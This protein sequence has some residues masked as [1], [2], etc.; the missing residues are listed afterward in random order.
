M[1]LEFPRGRGRT[2]RGNRGSGFQLG[3]SRDDELSIGGSDLERLVQNALDDVRDTDTCSSVDANIGVDIRRGEFAMNGTAHAGMSSQRGNVFDSSSSDAAF[4]DDAGDP[5][6]DVRRALNIDNISDGFSQGVEVLPMDT[7]DNTSEDSLYGADSDNLWV[8]PALLSARGND[9]ASRRVEVIDLSDIENVLD[10]ASLAG[11]DMVDPAAVFMAE[12][13]RKQPQP[14]P[15]R[16]DLNEP[17]AESPGDRLESD[18]NR[19]NRELNQLPVASVSE[20][21][22]AKSLDKITSAMRSRS[23]SREKVHRDFEDMV[24]ETMQSRKVG[25]AP[26]SS[27]DF[28]SDLRENLSTCISSSD[29]KESESRSNS[30]T[31]TPLDIACEEEQRTWGAGADIGTF[32]DPPNAQR[33]K[34]PDNSPSVSVGTVFSNAGVNDSFLQMPDQTPMSQLLGTPVVQ[35]DPQI[36]GPNRDVANR[37]DKMDDM[38]GIG[39]AVNA[40]IMETVPLMPDASI[41]IHDAQAGLKVPTW[42]EKVQKMNEVQNCRPASPEKEVSQT[43]ATPDVHPPTVG[44]LTSK[45]NPEDGRGSP[46]SRSRSQSKDPAQGKGVKIG[47]AVSF[48]GTRRVRSAER[49]CWALSGGP[50]VAA[51]AAD[52][53]ARRS[54]TR[55]A[56][57][58]IRTAK[59]SSSEGKGQSCER[60][61]RQSMDYRDGSA[62][63]RTLRSVIRNGNG[64]FSGTPKKGGRSGK[65]PSIRSSDARRS[66]PPLSRATPRLNPSNGIFTTTNNAIVLPSGTSIHIPDIPD[67]NIV[68]RPSS[69]AR[70]GPDASESGEVLFNSFCTP[71]FESGEQAPRQTA[72]SHT[73]ES[74]SIASSSL[75]VSSGRP[76]GGSDRRYRN[77]SRKTSNRSNSSHHSSL[78]SP[79]SEDTSSVSESTSRNDVSFVSRSG[80]SAT[81]A[82]SGSSSSSISGS[83]SATDSANT[84]LTLP[85]NASPIS[86]RSG[87]SSLCSEKASHR[88]SLAGA[89]VAGASVAGSG[90]AHA[91]RS[92]SSSQLTPGGLRFTTTGETTGSRGRTRSSS[93]RRTSRVLRRTRDGIRCYSVGPRDDRPGGSK[94]GTYLGSVFG[95]LHSLFVG[96][97]HVEVPDHGDHHQNQVVSQPKVQKSTG[98]VTTGII[99]NNACSAAPTV[100]RDPSGHPS[101]H[102]RCEERVG[103]RRASKKRV[104]F[105]DDRRYALCCPQDDCVQTWIEVFTGRT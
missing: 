13:Q 54:R 48:V 68:P 64:S 71:A 60:R 21:C 15:Q 23:R 20:N 14:L 35:I 75:V 22:L 19:I 11:S 39:Q 62:G 70:L 8:Q 34:R 69:V 67:N 74:S 105:V 45:E 42:A 30:V 58:S 24:L 6:S 80:S 28:T 100:A 103:T 92:D 79:G 47:G 41:Q 9:S 3:Y 94:D 102:S 84:S 52:A 63:K 65:S 40:S 43:G 38:S 7:G 82:K 29:A 91:R 25:M 99:V 12:G 44:T 98:N 55:S 26:S 89:S 32:A 76:Q 78:N 10:S 37:A 50:V 59:R 17:F 88:A 93:E 49:Q 1:P 86:S 73:E 27:T 36:F 96:Y 5:P 85:S 53:T 51:L 77:S 33:R 4:S 2:G 56:S 61:R 31:V 97:R 101:E 90:G 66:V 16:G 104:S 72:S 46:S 81:N 95:F 57:R 18:I 83:S 87:A